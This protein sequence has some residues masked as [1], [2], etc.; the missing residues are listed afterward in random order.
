MDMIGNLVRDLNLKHPFVVKGGEKEQIQV[1]KILM[2]QDHYIENPQSMSTFELCE[3]NQTIGQGNVFLTDEKQSTL[4][5]PEPDGFDEIIENLDC[6][7]NEE[8]YIFKKETKEVYETYFINDVKVIRR[9]ATASK[10]NELI[11]CKDPV[12]VN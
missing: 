9:V 11:W 5:I 7:I 1:I 4:M 10:R 8:L 2:N 6:S 3:S 12:L